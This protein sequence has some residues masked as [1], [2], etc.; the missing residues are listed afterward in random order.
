MSVQQGTSIAQQIADEGGWP[1][2][3]ASFA[4]RVAA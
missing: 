3:L 1:G 4:A 2:C